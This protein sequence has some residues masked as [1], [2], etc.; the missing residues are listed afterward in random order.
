VKRK[1]IETG[2]VKGRKSAGAGSR[3][4]PSALVRR[5]PGASNLK[6]S[7]PSGGNLNKRD[8][9]PIVITGSIGEREV[10]WDK[11]AE[12]WKANQIVDSWRSSGMEVAITAG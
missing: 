3:V 6:E 7:A 4:A 5:N 9:R 8:E 2:R 10:A 11:A 1:P 12:H